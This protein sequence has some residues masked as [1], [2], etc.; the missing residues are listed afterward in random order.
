MPSL[1]PNRPI[2]GL[3]ALVL[4]A[5]LLDAGLPK[6]ELEPEA[7]ALVGQLLIASP[8]MRDPRFQR[9]VILLMR[10]G[11]EGGIGIA[12]NRPVGERSLASVLDGLGEKGASVEGSVRFFAGGPVQPEIGF[13]VH[14]PDYKRP[15][16]F[17]I[18]KHIAVTSSREIISDIAHKRGPAKALVA[19]G[20]AGWGPGQLEDELERDYWVLVPAD[21]ALVFDADRDKVWDEAMANG[22][23]TPRDA[24]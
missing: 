22:G 23:Q 10:Y 11:P 18:D 5:S 9:T 7:A 2:L 21:P 16:T 20:Y 12:I 6:H 13:V 14:T 3:A 8:K 17:A 24:R 15:Q 19:F 4:S 1:W